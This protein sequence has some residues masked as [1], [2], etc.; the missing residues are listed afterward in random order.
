MVNLRSVQ[1]SKPMALATIQFHGR[2][3]ILNVDLT[4]SFC[5]EFK[6]SLETLQSQLVI[7]L[8]KAPVDFHSP[9]I[10]ITNYSAVLWAHKQ[11]SLVFQSMLTSM[12]SLM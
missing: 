10:T 2:Y 1:L 7:I 5:C 8:S 12:T 3:C 4:G 9:L 11:L 6:F